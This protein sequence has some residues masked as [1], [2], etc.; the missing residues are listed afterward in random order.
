MMLVM[1][2]PMPHSLWVPSGQDMPHWLTSSMMV[3]LRPRLPRFWL[4]AVLL[5]ADKMVVVNHLHFMVQV[6]QNFVIFRHL[7]VYIVRPLSRTVWALQISRMLCEIPH[8]VN[9]APCM[10]VV[11]RRVSIFV[12]RI[13]ICM[14]VVQQFTTKVIVTICCRRTQFSINNCPA[15]FFIFAFCLTPPLPSFPAISGTICCVVYYIIWFSCFVDKLFLWR[16]YAVVKLN[17][18][19]FVLRDIPLFRSGPYHERAV[20]QMKSLNIPF[21]LRWRGNFLVWVE[22]FEAFFVGKVLQKPYEDR[23]VLVVC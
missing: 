23:R 11:Y 4:L 1:R 20:F 21:G 6:A 13:D 8:N 14:L 17:K 2:W 7:F 3:R 5:I 19:H 9:P 22:A 16:R 18:A 10:G 15:I 12:R